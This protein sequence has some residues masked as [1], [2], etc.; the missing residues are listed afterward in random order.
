VT[1]ATLPDSGRAVVDGA[2]A[3]LSIK[4]VS[5]TFGGQK[6]L[7]EATLDLRPGEVHALLGMN[8]CGKSTLIKVL[9]GVHEA[10]GGAHIEVDG[11][12]VHLS[13][14]QS[15]AAGFRFV[16]QDLG[17]IGTLSAAENLE[18]TAQ[19]PRAWFSDRALRARA[20]RLL[21]DYGVDIDVDVPVQELTRAQQSLIAIV[22]AIADL[23]HGKGLLVLDE[24]TASLPP[25]DVATLVEALDTIRSRGLAVLMVTHR[26]DEVFAAAQRITVLRD[27]RTVLTCPTTETT[28]EELTTA[29]IGTRLTAPAVLERRAPQLS[30]TATQPRTPVLE[31]SGL[32]GRRVADVS[33]S[34]GPGEIVGLTGLVG[35]GYEEALAYAFG[36]AKREAGTVRVG[37]RTV[38]AGR[39]GSAVRAGMGY[40]PS[41]RDRLGSIPAWTIAENLT[42]PSVPSSRVKLLDLRRERRES[43]DWTREL[44]VVPS[45]VNR[46]LAE[47]SGGNRQRIALGRWLRRGCDVLLLDEPTIGVDVAGKRRIYDMLRQAAS[48]GV[49]VVVAS[50]DHPELIE[51]CDRIIVLRQGEVVARFE[52]GEATEQRLFRAS[53][54]SDLSAAGDHHQDV[55][56]TP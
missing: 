43:Q 38:P 17:L 53:V 19:R 13:T 40:V 4:S 36:A 11:E 31:V 15:H 7:D 34:V 54:G 16:H 48:D 55:R 30:T 39:C 52:A 23:P 37:S 45:D 24:P 2:P 3:F 42:L 29:I 20:R 56:R 8:G 28:R 1:H 18:L 14:R 44:E 33:F 51:L 22:R 35:S 32:V 6:A 26:M 21:G 12:T 5:K 47:L 50:S 10:D 27:G 46:R 49:A 9:A 41:D 25:R